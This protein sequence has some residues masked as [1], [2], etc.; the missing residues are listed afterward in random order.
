[1]LRLSG[2]KGLSPAVQE[3]AVGL[4]VSAGAAVCVVL[5]HAFRQIDR[6]TD[7]KAK[8]ADRIAAVCVVLCHAFRQIDRQTDA[9]AKQ[10][11]R[12][13]LSDCRRVSAVSEMGCW[14]GLMKQ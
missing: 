4:G 3:N 13:A 1:M 12:I 14:R 8:Q 9:K 5:C 6:Q 7:A 10:A 2:N 11:D